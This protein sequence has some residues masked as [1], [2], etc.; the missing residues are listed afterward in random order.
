MTDASPNQTEPAE[1]AE[2]TPDGPQGAGDPGTKRKRPPRWSDRQ[3]EAAPWY[4]GRPGGGPAQPGW[5]VATPP[6]NPYTGQGQGQGQSQGQGQG[7][8]HPQGG[9]PWQGGHNGQPGQVGQ[10]PQDG[11]QNA[12]QNGQPGQGGQNVPG[13]Q[14]QGGGQ[15]G[16]SGQGGQGGQ[17]VP[18]D[19]SPGAQPEA[20]PQDLQS[21]QP[22]DGQQP[23][24]GQPPVPPPYGV[25]MP[26][27]Q[28]QPPYG[29]PPQGQPGP[30]GPYGPYGQPG[31]GGHPQ[32]PPPPWHDPNRYGQQPQRRPDDPW[33]RQQQRPTGPPEPRGPLDLRTR[34]ARGLA[35]GSV[36]CTITAI[37]HS[38]SNFPTWLVGAGV[39]LVLGMVGLWLGVFAQRAAQAKGKRAPEAVGAIVWSAIASLI[40]LMII[41]ISLIFY[42]QFSQLSNCMHSAT[43]IAAQNQ[44]E[45]NFEHQFGGGGK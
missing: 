38:I 40:S 10:P 41:A 36:V 21:G 22:A 39:G 44:C 28:A 19:R 9:V 12:G 42:T 31:P 33:Q 30:Y 23:P 25:P 29:Q 17:N 8:G 27:P 6:Q 4:V 14:P 20:Q 34:W 16:E 2:E 26:P 37:W 3:P 43:T 24:A 18:G 45:T 35:L 11:G 13:G 1:P 32:G 7:Q 5:G 15:N